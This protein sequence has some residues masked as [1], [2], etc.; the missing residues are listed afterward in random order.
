MVTSPARGGAP[1]YEL[2]L[3][4]PFP[5]LDVVPVHRLDVFVLTMGCFPAL[6]GMTSE[7]VEGPMLA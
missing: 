2:V 7:R 1:R 6:A 3:P 5:D 4:D